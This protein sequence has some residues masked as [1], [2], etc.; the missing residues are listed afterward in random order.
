MIIGI[1]ASRANH[2]QK[3][4]V[5]WYAYH[6]IQELKKIIP[7][8]I[9]VVLYADQPLIGNLAD[10]PENWTQKVLRWLPKRLW[11]QIRLSTEMILRRPDI[12]FIPAHVFPIIHPKK[13]VMTIHDVAA[14]RFPES[15]SRFERWYSV[16]SARFAVK[17][18]WRVIA[19]SEFT[20]RE[21][22][23]IQK[24][25]NKNNIFVVS[26]GYNSSYDSQRN[27][28]DIEEILKRYRV[29]RPYAISIGRLEKKKNT[30]RIVKAFET[31]HSLHPLQLVLVGKSGYGYEEVR[32]VIEASQFKNDIRELGWLSPEDLT[33]LLPNAAVFVF[34]SLYEGFG[35]P[36]L[37][38]FAAG[39]PVIASRGSS[40]EEVGGGAALYVDPENVSEIARAIEQLLNNEQLRA[41]L[42]KAGQERVKQFFWE[43]CA[44][45]TLTVLVGNN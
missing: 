12:L 37:E 42:I 39:V 32:E 24:I 18:L 2:E 41:T 10:L 21:I 15:Y 4:G 38:A 45:E 27:E 14:L 44:R 3:T 35:L 11:T 9:S 29:K 6:I 36:V 23:K 28:K 31:V 5:E 30:Q 19:P 17:H 43:K 33:V 22:K 40:L 34:P 7:P 25:E 20:G 1:D 16:W 8:S 13:T 26:L